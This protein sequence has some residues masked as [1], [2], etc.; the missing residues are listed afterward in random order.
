VVVV[1]VGSSTAAAVANEPEVSA[2]MRD[3]QNFSGLF[4]PSKGEKKS[5]FTSEQAMKAQMGNRGRAQLF[6]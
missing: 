2:N 5:K 4:F 3:L 6:L 1:V